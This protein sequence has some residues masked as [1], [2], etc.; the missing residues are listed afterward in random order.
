LWR[1]GYSNIGA[2]F[3]FFRSDYQGAVLWDAALNATSNVAITVAG[4]DNLIPIRF[5]ATS[6]SLYN[7]LVASGPTIPVQTDLRFHFPGT[8][9]IWDTG[10]PSTGSSKCDAYVWARVKYIETG[11]CD[12]SL[13]LYAIDGYWM[14]GPNKAALSNYL[15]IRDYIVRNKGF[16]FDLSPW[17]DEK[18]I[19]DPNQ[20]LGADLN[21]MK[22][23]LAAAAARAPGMIEMVGFCPVPMKYSNM[24]GAGGSLHDPVSCEWEQ[25]KWAT[26]YNAYTDADALAGGADIGN[27]SLYCQ[28]EMPERLT[29]NRKLSQ[30]ELRKLGYLDKKNGLSPMNYLNIYIGDYDSSSWLAGIAKENWDDPARG[31]VPMSW[32]FNPNLIK[33]A[34][35]IYAYYNQTRTAND[36]FIAGDSGAGYVNPT[37]L[38]GTRSSGLPSAINMWINH[39]LKYFRQTNTKITGFLINGTAGAITS[40]A[41]SMYAAFSVD[42][43]FSQGGW[44]QQGDHMSS[45][46]PALLQ[47]RDLVSDDNPT[48]SVNIIQPYGQRWTPRFLNFRSVIRSPSWVQSVFEDVVTTD[49]TLPWTLID[50]ATYTALDGCRLGKS[51][52]CRA[53]YTFDTIPSTVYAGVLLTSTI[54]VRND[55]WST[56]LSTGAN[57]VTLQL[58][59]MLGTETISSASATLPR[60]IASSQGV[61]LDLLITPPSSPGVYTLHYEMYRGSTSFT[62]LGDYSWENTVTVV[63]PGDLTLSAAKSQPDGATVTVTGG[64]VTAGTDQLYRRFYMEQEDRIPGIQVYAGVFQ[65]TLFIEG[66]RVSLSGTMTTSGNERK[67]LLQSVLFQQA[68]SPLDPFGMACKAVGGLDPNELTPG[69]PN[70]PGAYNTGLLISVYGTVSHVSLD[71]DWFYV[72]DGGGARDGTGNA[73]VCVYLLDLATNNTITP[74]QVGDY[75]AVTGIS[76]TA[77]VNSLTVPA[78]R[79]RKQADIRLLD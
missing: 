63:A 75:I 22:S 71:N 19:D 24:S 4:A 29:Q 3:S 70:N 60:D 76:S 12:P 54:G 20:P 66:D 33:R 38:I 11:K 10:L 31:T 64:V 23:I 14:T 46:M 2:L 17:G 47:Q 79:P 18:P 32:A 56:W 67:I 41:D 13:L 57:M 15:P 6:E 74:P 65:P 58:K 49:T 48:P 44:Y 40:S 36:F 51:P 25:V 16:A 21:T 37:R 73:G 61:T 72:N 7:T 69:F 9:T 50:A 39:N 78:V 62:S 8:G 42:G 34:G 68:G 53:T 43:T 52:D 27:A 26:F 45:T 30:T 59:W 35:P 77:F 28:F 5:D 1:S 55:G